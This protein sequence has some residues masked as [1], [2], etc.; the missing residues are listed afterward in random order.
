MK[1]S[2]Y[3]ESKEKDYDAT[4]TY[5]KPAFIAIAVSVVLIILLNL[6]NTLFFSR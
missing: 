5:H 3:I 1:D 4:V 6:A 2:V